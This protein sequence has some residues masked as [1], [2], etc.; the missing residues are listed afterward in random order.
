MGAC[1]CGAY[2]YF[3]VVFSACQRALSVVLSR[4]TLGRFPQKELSTMQRYSVYKSTFGVFR[5]SQ[6][7]LVNN[8]K[9]KRLPP[10]DESLCI[11]LPTIFPS[12]E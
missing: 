7:I 6:H 9:K 5:R 2:A 4:S 1:A 8:G 10:E 11:I 12:P 3:G